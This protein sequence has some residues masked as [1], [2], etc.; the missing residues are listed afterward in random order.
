MWDIRAN[1]GAGDL[2]SLH[3]LAGNIYIVQ[4]DT[5][6]VCELGS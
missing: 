3:E 6:A 4:T 1:V 5:D 2:C